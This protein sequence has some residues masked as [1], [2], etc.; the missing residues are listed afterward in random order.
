MMRTSDQDPFILDLFLLTA[1][2]AQ[3]GPA[4]WYRARRRTARNSIAGN[5][6]PEAI[7]GVAHLCDPAYAPRARRCD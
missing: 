3:K 1:T 4:C 7:L 2:A 5:R 6:E